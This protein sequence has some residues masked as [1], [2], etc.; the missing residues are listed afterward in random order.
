M[1]CSVIRMLLLTSIASLSVLRCFLRVSVCAHRVVGFLQSV[2]VIVI[3]SCKRSG[4]GGLV[5]VQAPWFE[6]GWS[7]VVQSVQAIVIRSC[8]RSGQGGLVSVLVRLVESCAFIRFRI[9]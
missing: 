6:S 3:R 4:Q 1:R 9:S 5:S 2:Q 7:R 8:K